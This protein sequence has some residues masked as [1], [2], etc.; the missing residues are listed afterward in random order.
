MG[1]R[2]GLLGSLTDGPG[3]G[4]RTDLMARFHAGV[5]TA[6]QNMPES[7][8]GRG[9]DVGGTGRGEPPRGSGQ[10]DQRSSGGHGEICLLEMLA[11]YPLE[12]L[13]ALA[14]LEVMEDPS[15][16][17]GGGE[18]RGA[19]TTA[20]VVG[21]R[22]G[23]PIAG[24]WVT[25]VTPFMKD[26]S[27]SSAAWVLRCSGDL[28]GRWLTSEPTERRRPSRLCRGPGLSRGDK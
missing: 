12:D 26:P 21:E 2:P 3:D 9:G 1:A 10:G 6:A 22:S 25:S 17:G 28:C 5:G 15:E 11:A 23:A 8:G 24:D 13:E 19:T 7:E 4:L 18:E 20:G 14:I 16:S 27:S